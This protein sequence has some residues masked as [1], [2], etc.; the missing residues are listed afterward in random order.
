MSGLTKLLEQVEDLHHAIYADDVTLWPFCGSDGTIQYGCNKRLRSYPT[1]LDGAASLVPPHQSELLVFR[2]RSKN[3][4]PDIKVLV[5]GALIPQVE[6]APIL[7]FYVQADGN[8]G[9]TIS[10]LPRQTE[11]IIA[12]FSVA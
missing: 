1:M 11:Q 2:L 3:P 4:P 7:G 9:H 5:E 8:A 10:L 12:I 6:R